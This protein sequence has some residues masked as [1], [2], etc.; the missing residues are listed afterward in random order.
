MKRVIVLAF[1]VAVLV[2]AGL[3][4]SYKMTEFAQTIAT[5]EVEGFGIVAVSVY[6]IGMLPIVFVTMWA[7][8]TGRFRD[9]ERPKFRMLEL[10]EEITRGGDERYTVE[11]ALRS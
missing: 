1:A 5:D 6:L 3:G 8:F 11:Q 7:L 2:V 4:F 10:D 9:I